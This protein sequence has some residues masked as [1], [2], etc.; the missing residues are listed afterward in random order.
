MTLAVHSLNGSTNYVPYYRNMRLGQFVTQIVAPAIG[1]PVSS[2][3][4]DV[5]HNRF[6]L[7]GRIVFCKD[8]KDKLVGDVMQ[9]G[10][11]LYHT[12]NMGRS[13][14]CLVGNGSLKRPTVFQLT[15]TPSVALGVKA[16]VAECKKRKA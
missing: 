6:V 15:L 2:E 3:T 1:C 8:N 7:N 10:D 13:D 14:N 9:E 4:G 16:E 12:L 5:V 11:K